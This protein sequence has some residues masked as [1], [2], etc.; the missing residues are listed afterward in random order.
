M[1][2]KRE[3]LGLCPT[4]SSLSADVILWERVT[5]S[6]ALG[7]RMGGTCY[8]PKPAP[9]LEAHWEFYC[10]IDFTSSRDIVGDEVSDVLQIFWSDYAFERSIRQGDPDP[11]RDGVAYLW[12]DH[13]DLVVPTTLRPLTAPR[14]ACL[15]RVWEDDSLPEFKVHSESGAV[16]DCGVSKIGGIGTHNQS[17]FV[18]RDEYEPGERCLC[19]IEPDCVTNDPGPYGYDGLLSEWSLLILMR[20]DGTIRL[21]PNGS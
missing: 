9:D 15:V 17:W 14:R 21:L 18:R 7:T 20:E 10:Q 8:G 12:R 5:E 6:P 3:E 11:A 4:G 2:K 16:I 19:V 13:A 1:L